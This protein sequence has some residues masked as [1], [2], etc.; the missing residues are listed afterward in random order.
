MYMSNDSRRHAKTPSPAYIVQSTLLDT[1][2]R[3]F[4]PIVTLS[5]LG[6]VI[7]TAFALRP[8]CMLG[9]MAIAVV[10]TAYLIARQIKQVS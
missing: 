5:V 6:I 4:V 7:D 10:I 8:W 9:G 1:T 3:M 2:W